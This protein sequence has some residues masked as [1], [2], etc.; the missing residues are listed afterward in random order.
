ML[1]VGSRLVTGYR[2]RLVGLTQA[3]DQRLGRPAQRSSLPVVGVSPICLM[4]G[5]LW[6]T[7]EV[8][9]RQGKSRRRLIPQ[10]AWA[11][12]VWDWTP[13]ILDEW[14]TEVR[15][16]FGT[17][18]NPAAWPSERGP[19]VGCQRLNSRFIA[20]RQAL[21]LDDGLD[22]HHGPNPKMRRPREPADP[23]TQSSSN[24]SSSSGASAGPASAS[25]VRQVRASARSG[26]SGTAASS[27]RLF[28]A[29]VSPASAAAAE[30]GRGQ[31]ERDEARP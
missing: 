12:G 18:L 16:L 17:D 23:A 8:A 11:E 9:S 25:R 21:G 1:I 2:L 5:C 22:F 6:G 24:C 28:C 13:D 10:R 20:H 27:P 4:S 31:A 14:F 3:A 26:G 7:R 15:P 19:R 30:A 29:P